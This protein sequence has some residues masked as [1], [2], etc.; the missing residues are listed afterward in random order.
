M[1][2][3]KH[4]SCSQFGETL[5]TSHDSANRFLLR[6]QYEPLDLYTEALRVINPV[7]GVLS[8]DDTVLDK[9]YANKMAYVSYFGS[10]KHHRTVKGIN[11]IT[12]YYT[13]HQGQSAPINY[14]LYDK[15]EGK[16]KN[17]YFLEM[18]EEVLAWGLKPAYVT[19]DS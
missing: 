8:V 3:P 17:D 6:E 18:L 19:A 7:G 16:S 5:G 9:P 13:D 1:S 10:G 2:E 12:L 4:A 11:L 14:R 15:T